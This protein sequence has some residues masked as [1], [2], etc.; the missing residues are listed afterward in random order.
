[1][2]PQLQAERQLLA[3]EAASVPHMEKSSRSSLIDRYIARARGEA[4]RAKSFVEALMAEG[5]RV[6]Q[7]PASKRPG[8]ATGRAG[9]RRGVKRG[10]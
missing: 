4:V 3:I 5:V 6:V 10:R 8:K 2:L 9:T 1:M 7:V